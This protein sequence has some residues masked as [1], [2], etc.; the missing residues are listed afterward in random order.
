MVCG[1]SIKNPT[2]HTF[3]T[4]WEVSYGVVNNLF[5]SFS[6]LYHDQKMLKF[7]RIDS[8][9]VFLINSVIEYMFSS[10]VLMISIFFSS[11]CIV[12]DSM[13]HPWWVSVLRVALVCGVI[14]FVT[15]GTLFSIS[16]SPSS[17]VV[18]P[19]LSMVTD[20]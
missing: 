8:F 7:L 5:C 10:L 14:H 3:S 15:K 18:V 12:V 9:K 11:V 20:F 19:A 16:F 2:I 1:S 13:L 17:A 6:I 4:C